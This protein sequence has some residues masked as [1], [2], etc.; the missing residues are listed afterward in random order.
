MSGVWLV[1]C[2]WITRRWRHL[3]ALPLSAAALV[4]QVEGR[5]RHAALC[6]SGARNACETKMGRVRPARMATFTEGLSVTDD[7]LPFT[8]YIFKR[9]T[10]VSLRCLC[11]FSWAGVLCSSLPV[12]HGCD[13]PFCCWV[14]FRIYCEIIE[15]CP[16]CTITRVMRM[17]GGGGVPERFI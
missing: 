10:V 8:E 4:G 13:P 5:W 16:K 7:R 12:W 6:H 3:G 15:N 1:D 17:G 9:K 2:V 14:S 11:C